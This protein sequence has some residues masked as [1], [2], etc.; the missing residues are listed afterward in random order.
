MAGAFHYGYII[1]TQ[2]FCIG[3]IV[4]W[5]SYPVLWS[6]SSKKFLISSSLSHPSPDD[7]AIMSVKWLNPFSSLLLFFFPSFLLLK[8]HIV[9][10]IPW[11][12]SSYNSALLKAVWV[13]SLVGE[14]RTH[15][16]HSVAKKKKSYVNMKKIPLTDT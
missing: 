11:Q 2:N 1:P 7:G 8:I 12:S 15:K 6:F 16:P 5:L 3:W 10:V 13:Q 9:R 4:F 14:L